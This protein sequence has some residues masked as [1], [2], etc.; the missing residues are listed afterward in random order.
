MTMNVPPLNPFQI[1]PCLLHPHLPRNN[2]QDFK[3]LNEA[4]I[5]S[6]PCKKPR[7]GTLQEGGVKRVKELC[8]NARQFLQCS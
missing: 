3:R 7:T 6:Q 4:S 1:L 5:E 2:P 8:E